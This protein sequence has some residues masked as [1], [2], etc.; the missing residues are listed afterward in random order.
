MLGSTLV[1]Q[2]NQSVSISG[3]VDADIEQGWAEKAEPG[4]YRLD[5]RH[6]VIVLAA[7]VKR[8]G[9]GAGGDA[10]DVDSGGHGISSFS[11]PT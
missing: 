2:R 1:A 4:C 7:V 11:N 3:R 5:R 10:G 6:H 8:I 9:K